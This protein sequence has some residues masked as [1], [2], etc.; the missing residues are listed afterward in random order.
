MRR[1]TISLD[2]FNEFPYLHYINMNLEPE[3]PNKYRKVVHA[4]LFFGNKIALSKRLK[5][6]FHK[7]FWSDAGG[8]VEKNE[9]II[10]AIVRETE[11]ETGIKLPPNVFILMDSFIYTERQIK[12]F[13]F[14]VDLSEFQ[15]ATIKNTEPHKQGPWELFTV[16]DALKLKLVPS[17]KYYLKN[18]NGY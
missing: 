9:R 17:V 6:G 15:F 7:G 2:F 3:N 8:K 4:A 18:L 11:E 10:D 12:T 14:K 5:D 1:F 16:K 13:L